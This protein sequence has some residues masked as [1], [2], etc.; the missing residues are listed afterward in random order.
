MLRTFAWALVCCAGVAVIALASIPWSGLYVYE[1]VPPLPSQAPTLS[2]SAWARTNRITGVTEEYV[3]GRWLTLRRERPLPSTERRELLA[4]ASLNADGA[5]IGNLY[6][7]TQ[8]IVTRV[9]LRVDARA[10]RDR[11]GAPGGPWSRL[12]AIPLRLPPYSTTLL[13]APVTDR[14][15]LRERQLEFT[16]WSFSE[17]HGFPP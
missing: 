10:V 7:G 1:P 3:G 13:H 9:I 12:I 15:E 2:H 4:Y 17:A 6:N 8:W 14:L 11:P 16:H 5:L